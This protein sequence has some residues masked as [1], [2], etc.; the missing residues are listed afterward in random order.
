MELLLLLVGSTVLFT[1]A[2]YVST[3]VL[4]AKFYSIGQK[5]VQCLLVWLLPL[6][7]AVIVH[8]FFRLHHAEPD[9]PDRAFTPQEEPSLDEMRAFHHRRIDDGNP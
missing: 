5:V 1:Y 7:G 8:W 4:A 2:W 3:L 6:V 9:K